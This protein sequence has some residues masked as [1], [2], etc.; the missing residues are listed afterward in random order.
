MAIAKKTNKFIVKKPYLALGV[1]I[2][3]GI[4]VGLA[5][6]GGSSED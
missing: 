2:G 1:G 5:S 6:R 4:L 3:V